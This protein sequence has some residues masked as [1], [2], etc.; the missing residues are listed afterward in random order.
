[1]IDFRYIYQLCA[2]KMKSFFS[3]VMNGKIMLTKTYSDN[4][5][6]S[7]SFGIPLSSNILIEIVCFGYPHLDGNV[8]IY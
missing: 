4:I 3:S 6:K 2:N 7:Q 1:M 8:N 5:S